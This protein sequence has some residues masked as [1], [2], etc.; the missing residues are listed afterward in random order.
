MST[1]HFLPS[2]PL[3]PPQTPPS[4]TYSPLKFMS[5]IIIIIVLYF[6]H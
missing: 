1:K 5:S 4:P 6:S 2:L 3:L